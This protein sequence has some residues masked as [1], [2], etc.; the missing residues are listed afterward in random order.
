[1]KYKIEKGTPVYDQMDALWKEASRCHDASYE[2]A[3]EFGTTKIARSRKNVAGGIAAFQLDKKPEG[4]KMVG[5]KEQRLYF[6]K[7]NLKELIKRINDLPVI[8]DEQVCAI[9]NF[10]PQTV[11][12][13][14]GIAFLTVPTIELKD[15][16]FLIDLP[17]YAKWDVPEGVVEILESEYLKLSETK[18]V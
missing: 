5:K 6:P 3:G 2:L 7:A 13:E 14:G 8:T 18:E 15:S 17:I 12:T 1:M 16:V 9:L 11:S 4:W 10:K